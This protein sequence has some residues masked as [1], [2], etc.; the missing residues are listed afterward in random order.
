MI[1]C[2][3]DIINA[4]ETHEFTID[5]EV[6]VQQFESNNM[7]AILRKNSTDCEKDSTKFAL[8]D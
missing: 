1:C 3:N 5:K 7:D 6:I 2:C 8:K 4:I